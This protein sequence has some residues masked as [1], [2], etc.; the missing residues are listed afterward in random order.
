MI[1]SFLGYQVYA[2]NLPQSLQ[3]AA[4]EPVVS[5]AQTYY[6]ANIGSVT[7][8]SALVNN[9]KLLSYATQAFGLSDMTYAKALLT[10]VL[11]S[12]LTSSTSVANQLGGNYLAFA[13][14]FNF[15]TDG[16]VKS[17][18]Q[19]QT[20]SQQSQT[21]SLF[22][23][24]TSLDTTDAAT[25]T[26]AYGAA[27]GSLTSLTQLEQ[28]PATLGYVL[29]AY[30]IDP[31]TAS[32]TFE[33][34]LESNLADPDSFV[35]QQAASGYLAL[36]QAVNVDA[37]GNA[38]AQT[39]AET[40]PNIQ[41]TT[42]AYLSNVGTDSASQ[43]AAATATS[44]FLSKISGI[45]S[46]SQ[47][48]SDSQLMAYLT[49]A[50]Q[51]PSSATAATIT[52][53]LTSD[54]TDATSYANQSPYPGYLALAKALNFTTGGAAGTVTQLQS[55]AQ[56]QS[57][58]ALYTAR[59][60]TD[61]AASAAATAYYD[62]NIGGIKSV[63]AL[64]GDSKLLNYVLTAYGIGASTPTATLSAIIENTNSIDTTTANASLLALNLAFNVDGDGN[65][66]TPLAAQTTAAVA[67]TAAAYTL[68]APTDAASQTAAKTATAYY[69]AAVANVTSVSGL[70]AD[71]KLVAYVEQAYS[72]PITTSAATLR[73]VLTSDLTDQKSV[74]NTLGSN[75]AKLS[76][77]FD[78]SSTGLVARGPAGPQSRAQLDA[79]NNAYLDQQIETEAGQQN[80]GTQLAL[81]LAFNASK[82]TSPYDI[83][84][85]P[86]LTQIFQVLQGL[87]ATASSSDIDA[88]AKAISAKFTIA[89]F[90]DPTYVKS[91]VERFSILYDLNPP[92]STAPSTTLSLFSGST[93]ALDVTSL[94]SGSSD[95]TSST[96]SA[97]G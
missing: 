44:Y 72:I 12:D 97:F 40:D 8:A 78:F 62:A 61:T 89:D 19:L 7:S 46:V 27:V 92:V 53:A 70:L 45:T 87:P 73:Q 30:G 55:T 47:L 91:L 23:A 37:G 36:S 74:A 56:Q 11:E 52:S 69:K 66:A 65:A 86:K 81:Y 2:N 3:R 17:S 77:A 26:S 79:V 82:V 1:S 54:T 9:Y 13:K 39:E 29:N 21:E 18:A 16:S 64:E 43:T 75:F 83:L 90:K 60:T 31:T 88:Q 14:A 33:Q 35:N 93:S 58:V 15:N 38:V 25:A 4:A 42:Q 80:P 96:S 57:T 71:P 51:L 59:Q 20:S 49:T 95:D 48:A 28:N 6:N 34:T 68:N 67:A 10:K 94:F 41:A 22:Q 76:A 32:S 24:G 85:D 50:Y 63:A 5:K 84:A